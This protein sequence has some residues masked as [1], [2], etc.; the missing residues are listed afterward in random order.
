MEP[1]KYAQLFE[2]IIG[3]KLTPSEFLDAR[4]AGFDPK[5]IKSIAKIEPSSAGNLAFSSDGDEPTVPMAANTEHS[6]LPT[7]GHE[8]SGSLDKP[9]Q[10]FA[11]AALAPIIDEPVPTVTATAQDSAQKSQARSKGRLI[12]IVAGICVICAIAIAAFFYYQRNRYIDLSSKIT[13]TF[14]GYDTY[15]YANYNSSEVYEYLGHE[16]A[17]KAGL[18]AYDVNLRMNGMG[19]AEDQTDPKY[20]QVASWLASVRITQDKYAHLSNGNVV[21]L[22]VSA[23]KGTPVRSFKKEFTVENLKK[24]Q[25]VATEELVKNEITFTGMN[26]SGVVTVSDEGLSIDEGDTYGLSNGDTVTVTLSQDYIDSLLEQGKAPSEESFTVKVSGL[27][28]FSDIGKMDTLVEMIAKLPAQAYEDDP[29]DEYESYGEQYTIESGKT[30]VRSGSDSNSYYGEDDVHSDMTISLVTAYKITRTT[31]WVE[32][33]YS[34]K[35]GDVE[36]EVMYTYF[37]YQN[38]NVYNGSLILSDLYDMQDNSDNHDMDAVY[39]ELEMDGYI[40]YASTL[41]ST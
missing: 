32:D 9:T 35:A 29:A 27:K 22:T 6:L 10:Q 11:P 20:K 28:N 34:N 26:G 15:G 37:G 16:L 13:M 21:T 31:T 8:E 4:A 12:A 38:V 36:T 40:E 5:G 41:P 30:Y 14:S 3:R 17:V 7:S 19:A 23:P 18:D 1:D 25:T 24:V 39:A 33:T 2:H